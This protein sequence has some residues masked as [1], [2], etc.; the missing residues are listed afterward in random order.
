MNIGQASRLTGLSPRAIRLYETSGIIAPATRGR[1]GYR[2]FSPEDLRTLHFVRN[3]RQLSFNL[4]EIEQMIRLWRGG[5]ETGP[6]IEAMFDTRLRR[7]RRQEA[8]LVANRVQ[9]EAIQRFSASQ[10][11]AACGIVSALV[12]ETADPLF[13]TEQAA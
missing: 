13:C 3:A 6:E 8:D 1:S 4:R 2:R 10:P 11:N 7:L 12:G 9:L 5:P